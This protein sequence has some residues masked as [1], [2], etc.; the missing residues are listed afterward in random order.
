MAWGLDQ[1]GVAEAARN[2]RLPTFPALLG[3]QEPAF[4]TTAWAVRSRVVLSGSSDE[5]EPVGFEVYSGIGIEA[6]LSRRVSRRLST[7]LA[8]RFESREVDRLTGTGRAESV[9]S[10]ELLPVSLLFCTL[11]LPHTEGESARYLVKVRTPSPTW[12]ACDGRGGQRRTR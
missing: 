9:G 1:E 5:S 8:M 7:E 12:S 6:A 2:E 10:V 3:A 11:C 4:P